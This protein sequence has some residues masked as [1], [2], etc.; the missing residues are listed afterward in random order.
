[1][2]LKLGTRF[3]L[4]ICNQV[5]EHLPDSLVDKFVAKLAAH[6]ERT[7]IV[8]TTFELEQGAIKGHVQDPISEAEFRSWFSKFAPRDTGKL[9]IVFSGDKF[10][11]RFRP[12]MNIIG[13]WTRL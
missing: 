3:D 12:K 7:L 4:V 11:G 9:E 13:V 6:T 1:M 8:S 2:A 10:G 5:V